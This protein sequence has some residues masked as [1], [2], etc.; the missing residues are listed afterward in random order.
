MLTGQAPFEGREGAARRGSRPPEP[1]RWSPSVSPDLDQV[2]LSAMDSDPIRRY[3]SA[4][5][6]RDALRQVGKRATS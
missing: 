5:S 1:S 4:A 3:E 2:V 6:L